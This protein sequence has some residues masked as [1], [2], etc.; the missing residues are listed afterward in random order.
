M[1]ILRYLVPLLALA[2]PALAQPQQPVEL[3]SHVYVTPG[4]KPTASLMKGLK[5]PKGFTIKTFAE[6]LGKPRM[7]QVAPDG[8]VYVTRRDPGD[9]WLL[10]DTN[11]DGIADVKKK[12]AE[13]KQM[14]GIFLHGDKLYLT[15][16]TEVFVAQRK[17]D[18]TLG[19]LKKIM[20][21][22]PDGGQH[23]NRTLAV[24]PD[25]KLYVSVGS[26]CNACAEP[27]PESATM[28]VSNLDGSGRKVYA[29]GLR[30]TIGFDWHPETKA[31]WGAD[32]G[33]DWL[34]D[35]DQPEELN[36]LL[37]DKRY[38]W[39]YIYAQGKI[40]PA[41]QPP[42]PCTS[43]KWKEMSKEPDLLFTAHSAPMQM[44]F[45]TGKMFPK[46]FRGDAL[47]AMHGSWNRMPPSGYEIQRVKF[48]GGKPVS[49]EPFLS[50]F[51]TQQDGEYK[52]F[53]RPV[54]LAQMADGSLL[55]SDDAHGVIYR[56]S[57]QP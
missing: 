40:N 28:L 17:P 12:V 50:G 22:L 51:L 18:G 53:G 26:T 37:P 3:E 32:H 6:G 24:G 46:E 47:I 9:C 31:F 45:Y 23:P 49:S 13:K 7:L 38:G 52:Q 8:S 57:Y 2:S 21:N 14:H 30:N 11:G 54:G 27:N 35:D 41:D 5:L 15:T 43:E 25:G 20:E 29:S 34:G 55:L 4:V 16:I 33:I 44:L 36:Q 19:P 1:R 56:I 39:P 42:A 48:E 10:K